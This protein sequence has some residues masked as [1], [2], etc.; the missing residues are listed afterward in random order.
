MPDY[1]I[2][3]EDQLNQVLDDLNLANYNDIDTQL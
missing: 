3:E 2:F 1:A